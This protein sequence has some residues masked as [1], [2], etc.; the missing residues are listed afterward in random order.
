LARRPRHPSLPHQEDVGQQTVWLTLC[1][2]M[3]NYS[4]YLIKVKSNVAKQRGGCLTDSFKLHAVS[5]SWS[6]CR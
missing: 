3:A 5:S 6:L 1:V 4:F 2:A